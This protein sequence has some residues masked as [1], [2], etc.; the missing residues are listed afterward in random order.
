MAL[1]LNPKF[2]V[3]DPSHFEKDGSA[4]L[5]NLQIRRVRKDPLSCDFARCAHFGAG[6]SGELG[7]AL[8]G[9]ANQ[10]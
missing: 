1:I 3:V 6:V 4:H 5:L 9:I 2:Y 8:Y 10:A 7:C